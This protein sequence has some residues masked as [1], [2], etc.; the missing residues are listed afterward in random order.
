MTDIVFERHEGLIVVRGGLSGPREARNL[1][2]V[3]DCAAVAT[4]IK[5]EIL[6]AIGYSALQ[7][8]A[9]TTV[10]TAIGQERGYI[11]DVI[12]FVCFNER[13]P[14]FRVNAFDLALPD[15]LDGLLG[16]NFLDRFN[17][18]IRS[19]EGRIRAELA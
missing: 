18:E 3:V 7:A 19:R 1:R 13:T 10:T 4:T 12:E 11:I 14:N 9:R 16:L 17:Y 5:T 15:H 6:D 8:L 2:L